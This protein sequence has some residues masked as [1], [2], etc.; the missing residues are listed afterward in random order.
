MLKQNL[1]FSGYK[2]SIYIAI[3][4]FFLTCFLGYV[5]N[6]AIETIVKKAII[7]ACAL[8]MVFFVVIKI[9]VS[10]IPD[11]IDIEEDNDNKDDASSD[12][13]PAQSP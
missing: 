6:L 11:N 3:S 12:D 4:A 9:V 1:I 5:S 7:S 10:N 2:L 8:G 13:G